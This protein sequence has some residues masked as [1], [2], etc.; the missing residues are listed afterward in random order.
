MPNI[1]NLLVE[2]GINSAAF[3]EGMDKATYKAKQSAKMI[4]D[5]F[6]GLGRDIGGLFGQLGGLG[7]VIGETLGQ[8]GE[9]L[10]KFSGQLGSVGG[11]AGIAAVGIAAIGGV[12]IA[13][14]A[15][16]MEMA[17]QGAELVHSL[18]M[19]SQKTGISIQ[20][21]QGLQA[22]GA[23]VGVSLDGMVMATRKFS[24]ALTG[25]GK[26]ASAAGITLRT[27]GV[28]SHS[29]G[30]ALLQVAEAFEKMPN[31]AQ[32]AADAVA[33][34]GREGLNLI[35]LLNKGKA[36]IEEFNAIV[37]AYGPKV[38]KDAVEADEKLM[39]A[40][41]KLTQSWDRFKVSAETAALP[42]ITAVKDYMADLNK[43]MSDSIE[44]SGILTSAFLGLMRASE[45]VA[46]GGRSELYHLTDDLKGPGKGKGAK[47]DTSA[48]DAAARKE[49]LA[50]QYWK[51]MIDGGKE[52]YKLEQL[53]EQI[54]LQTAAAKASGLA[55]DYEMLDVLKKQLPAIQDA[56]AAE[57]QRTE[58]M[59]RQ[60][61]ILASRHDGSFYNMKNAYGP[62]KAPKG[63]VEGDTSGL[64]GKPLGVQAPD[65]FAKDGPAGGDAGQALS[66][67]LASSFG[68]GKQLLTDFYDTWKS[69]QAQ[70]VES[71]NETYTDQLK[72]FQDLLTKQAISQNQFNIVKL[73]LEQD[74]QGQLKDLRKN[75]G[76]STFEDSFNDMFRTI[77]N[78]GHDFAASLTA[79][80]GGALE[81]LNSQLA[82]FAA[83]GKLNLQKLGT[84]FLENVTSSALKKGESMA[85]GALGL[86]GGARD[87]SSAASALFVT[88]T[89]TAALSSLSGFS[90]GSL[91]GALPALSA[92][93]GFNPLNLL[94]F[95]PGFASGGNFE[96]GRSFIAGE[97][98]PELITPRAAG[99]V[100]PN[101]TKLGGDTHYHTN[102]SFH[103]VTD[104]DSFKK[105]QAQMLNQ[106]TAAQQRSSRNS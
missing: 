26:G 23:T 54:A 34:F 106:I 28:T 45:A 16:I 88:D 74:L 90:G 35:P 49:A 21:L 71:I 38:G 29:T 65:E 68:T 75:T 2:L 39:V 67:A 11:A 22:A 1:G 64:W 61:S 46:T 27:L 32:K 97:N 42:A 104:H 37:D 44:K 18:D 10:A 105:N 94:S 17:L 51:T 101:G 25:T 40:N 93:G 79:D 55:S 59:K 57:H 63:V 8:A 7:G 92:G 13:A 12:A 80:I 33:L 19:A 103:G 48:V 98:G 50:V 14:G 73:Q 76:S 52:E 87:G 15:G 9:T 24:Q 69:Q 102:V 89:S 83:T 100:H 62:T 81:G 58:E 20:A 84:S 70:T 30:E 96:A 4:G 3:V 43:S 91:G 66:T 78:S 41:V 72:H 95:L 56:A 53:S 6:K 77:K 82:K 60:A 99:T 5:S 31:G 86:G 36:G 47:A 85:M